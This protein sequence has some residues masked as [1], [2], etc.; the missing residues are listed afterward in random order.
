MENILKNLNDR[1]KS[2]VKSFMKPVLQLVKDG[3]INEARLKFTARI[4]RP[5]QV[6]G[7]PLSN[8][9]QKA[10]NSMF[11]RATKGP[12]S[13]EKRAAVHRKANAFSRASRAK[14]KLTGRGGGGSMKMPQE[15]SKTALSKKTLMNKGGVVKA[16]KN[17]GA[18][19]NGRGP[20]FKGQ[21]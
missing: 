21:S 2:R 12:T 15:Y 6:L 11:N 9:E 5:A 14:A 8:A 16:M 19:M 18:V 3:K 1:S 17:G 10:M 4:E 7:G 20:K 13:A